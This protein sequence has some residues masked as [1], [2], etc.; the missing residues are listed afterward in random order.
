[1]TFD[2]LPAGAT[3]QDSQKLEQAVDAEEVVAKNEVESAG[4]DTS[5]PTAAEESGS[6]ES[7][8][9]A[10]AAAGGNSGTIDGTTETQ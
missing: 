10:A 9:G 7:G 6:T 4:G 8:D 2:P 5:V 3:P 1:M